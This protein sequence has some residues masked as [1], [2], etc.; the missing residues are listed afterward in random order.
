METRNMAIGRALSWERTA[1][2]ARFQCVAAGLVAANVAVTAVAPHIVRIRVTPGA[3]PPAKGFSYVVN[4]PPA[5]TFTIEDT[6][7]RVVIAT[8]RLAVVVDL[9]PWC[10]SFKT[11]DG[12][13]L[14][15][16]I[17][18][19]ANFGGRGRLPRLVL[20]SPGSRMTRLG[21]CQR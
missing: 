17:P 13:V 16:E 4:K 2:G 18:G 9:E 10:L 5:P 20:R 7:K 3:V 14:T 15:H 11:P 12:R 6:E 21:R 8:E 1:D 19:D